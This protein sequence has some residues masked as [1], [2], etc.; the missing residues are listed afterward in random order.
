MIP[1]DIIIALG[2]FILKAWSNKS[3]QT[4]ELISGRRADVQD[5]RQMQN[6][7]AYS[8]R[9]LSYSIASCVIWLTPV[10]APMLGFPIAVSMLMWEPGF[11]WFEGSNQIV[12]Q[13]FGNVEEATV[14]LYA[15][16]YTFYAIMTGFYF[17]EPKQRGF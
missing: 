11:L 5:A 9:R 17:G 6:K 13:T 2:S 7:E 12:W 16:M 14:V 1:F 10:L 4:A 15:P 8:S 3:Q